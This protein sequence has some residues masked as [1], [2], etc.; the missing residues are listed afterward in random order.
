MLAADTKADTTLPLRLNPA[1]SR[2]PPAML[3]VASNEVNVPTD[4]MFGCAAVLKVP[5]IPVADTLPP[6]MLPVALIFPEA[7][8]PTVVTLPVLDTPVP[9][10]MRLILNYR[11]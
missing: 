8:T 6:A 5:A 10:P 7:A 2:L 1:A 4:V 11:H 3:P 9:C